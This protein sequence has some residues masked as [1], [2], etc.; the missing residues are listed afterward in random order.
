MKK[1]NNKTTNKIEPRKKRK[2]YKYPS[3]EFLRFISEYDVLQKPIETLFGMIVE[4]WY[5]PDYARL[6]GNQLELH[7]IGW[8]GNEAII[9]A[10][11]ENGLLWFLTWEKSVRGGHHWFEIPKVFEKQKAKS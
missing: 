4:N 5:Y 8:S 11:M 7:T 3:P 2:E 1:K 9:E 6:K 10:M